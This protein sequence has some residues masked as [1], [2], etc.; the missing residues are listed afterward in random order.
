MSRA[1]T[2]YTIYVVT[3]GVALGFGS[4]I[5]EPFQVPLV[6]FTFATPW[7]I[8]ILTLNKLV[9][10]RKYSATQM[11]VIAGLIGTFTFYF[12]PPSPLAFLAILAGFSFDL[13][14]RFKTVNLSLFDL[15]L[16]HFAATV[17]G[18]FLVWLIFRVQLPDSAS[19]LVPVFYVA[20]TWH[21]V[22]AIFV[23][24]V[25]YPL[26]PPNNPNQLVK[27]IRDQIE[28]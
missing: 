11:Y 13:F 3:F 4:S 15:I 6:S 5:L 24:F 14:T 27:T 22:V 25:L 26:F 2:W 7:V 20:G 21:F 9:L 12:G 1:S 8:S 17:S 16:G 10:A 18:F 23:S 19:A 28:E